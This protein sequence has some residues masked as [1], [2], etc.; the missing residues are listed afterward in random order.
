[1]K[2]TKL[3]QWFLLPIA[4]GLLVAFFYGAPDILFRSGSIWAKLRMAFPLF[5]F[6]AWVALVLLTEQ[7]RF[8]RAFHAATLA[9]AGFLASEV[10][11]SVASQSVV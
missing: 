7:W 6:G 9:A 3:A 4:A 8:S 2:K 10:L 11:A 1:M 5:L